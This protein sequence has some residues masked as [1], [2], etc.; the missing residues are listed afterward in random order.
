LLSGYFDYRQHFVPLKK[1]FLDNEWGY[2]SSNLGQTETLNLS[3][4]MVQWILG[5]LGFILGLVFYQKDRKKAVL[6]LL[7]GL[8]AAISLMMI[9]QKSSLIWSLLPILSWLQFPWRFLALSGFFLSFLSAASIYYLH[10]WPKI[11]WSV[12]LVSLILALS[13]TFNFYQPKAWLNIS[14]QDKFSG[15]SWQK[16]LTISIF[17]YLPIYAKLP[18]NHIASDLPEVLNG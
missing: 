7:I 2:G 10:R 12:G 15:E 5:L 18:P 8:L 17:D 9:H 3:T 4:G 6:V 13:L 11:M 14:D 16:Q 1:I